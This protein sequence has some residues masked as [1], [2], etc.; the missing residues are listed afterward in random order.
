[1]AAELGEALGRI[2]SQGGRKR[3]NGEEEKERN[4]ESGPRGND[5]LPP[6]RVGRQRRAQEKKE[7]DVGPGDGEGGKEPGEERGGGKHAGGFY[8]HSRVLC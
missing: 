8:K 6:E 2:H 5:P 7:R 3:P 1:M 4:V